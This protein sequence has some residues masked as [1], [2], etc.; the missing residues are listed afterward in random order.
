MVGQ[1]SVPDWRDPQAYAWLKMADR[2]AFAWEWLRRDPLYRQQWRDA[3][4]AAQHGLV[5]CEDPSLDARAARP[6]WRSELDCAVLAGDVVDPGDATR[7]GEAPFDFRTVGAALRVIG[8]GH[9]EHVRIGDGSRVLR[10][11]LAGGGILERP[12]LIAWRLVG[13]TRL[14]PALAAL[15]LLTRLDQGI[16]AAW[17]RT[18]E[19]KAPRWIMALRVRDA[20]AAGASHQDMARGLFG[21]LV[22][23]ER[24]RVETPSLRLRIQRLVKVSRR[25]AVRS[26]GL[27]FE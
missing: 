15:H 25:L 18:T 12:V 14:A 7:A 2:G 16:E 19:A 8:R 26:P 1:A 10:F 9:V 22:D 4:R 21:T 13:V 20:Q 23:P 3:G 24:W 6:I 5:V 17:P 11:D 27:W